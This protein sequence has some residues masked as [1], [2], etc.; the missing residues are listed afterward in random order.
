MNDQQLALLP[1]VTITSRSLQL[2]E[3]STREHWVSCGTKIGICVDAGPFIIGDWLNEGIKKHGI[4]LGAFLKSDD[5]KVM[6]G[7]SAF[8]YD[9]LNSF[10]SVMEKIP[11]SHRIQ[12]VSFA[13]HQTASRLIK[14]RSATELEEA[15]NWLELAR[16][17]KLSLR[18]MAFAIA[19]RGDIPKADSHSNAEAAQQPKLALKSSV[20]LP[21][22]AISVHR[23]FQTIIHQL[24][25]R[26]DPLEDWT[27]QRKQAAQAMLEPIM[28]DLTKIGDMY[29]ALCK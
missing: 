3:S 8:S 16:H 24:S 15:K 22:V 29:V 26:E 1:D 14:S 12:G 2:P 25:D 11:S 6:P 17:K 18:E 10:A 13:H 23:Q 20:T 9:S 19:G 7:I 4:S 21:D 5:A 28:D 27:P